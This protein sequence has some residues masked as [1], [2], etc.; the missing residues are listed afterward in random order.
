[1]YNKIICP[2]NNKVYNIRSNMG[3]QILKNYIQFVMYGGSEASKKVNT[4]DDHNDIIDEIYYTL[5]VD[6]SNS[7]KI[8]KINKIKKIKK[9]K[10]DKFTNNEQFESLIT[11]DNTTEQSD[12]TA[13]AAAA[14]TTVAAPAA[15][16]PHHPETYAANTVSGPTKPASE[17]SS[18][19]VADYKK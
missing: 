11:L 10:D 2:L 19:Y 18:F 1:M 14:P 8:K 15:A 6:G 17:G 5:P 16:A 12:E 3:K 13:T 4:T 7:E 9:I